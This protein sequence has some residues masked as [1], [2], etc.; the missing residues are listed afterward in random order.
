MEPYIQNPFTPPPRRI[1]ASL[2]FFSVAAIA[3]AGCGYLIWTLIMPDSLPT[4]SAPTPAGTAQSE[5]VTLAAQLGVFRDRTG[6]YPAVAEGLDALVERP[7]GL[8][9][10]VFWRKL[11]DD[12]PLDP[13]KNPYQYEEVPG[14]P[15]TYRVFSKGPNA[16]NPA[17]DFSQTL[18]AAPPTA[19]PAPAAAP[20]GVPKFR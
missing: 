10:E 11:R 2:L 15:P 3:L 18:P 9:P 4:V 1:G 17:D 19:T 7:V 13:W 16:T 20:A 5:I 6:R 8:L 12:V 14:D